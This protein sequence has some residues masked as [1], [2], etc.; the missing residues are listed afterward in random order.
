METLKVELIHSINICITDFKKSTLYTEYLA[1]VN[2]INK[3]K[4]IESEKAG[5]DIG[6][7]RALLDWVINYKKDWRKSRKSL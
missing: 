7:D 4:W 6:W 1:E 2:E 3:H 5:K